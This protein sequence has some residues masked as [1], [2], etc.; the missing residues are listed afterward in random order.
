MPP[1]DDADRPRTRAAVREHWTGRTEDR[2]RT[3]CVILTGTPDDA[4]SARVAGLADAFEAAGLRPAVIPADGAGEAARDASLVLLA[5]VTHRT[6]ALDALIAR[7]NDSGRPTVVDVGAEALER[8]RDD[9]RLTPDAEALAV[10]C[11]A[12]VAPNGARLTAARAAAPRTMALPTLLTR[13]RVSALREARERATPGTPLVVGW[14]IGATMPAAYRDAVAEGVAT[15]LE[16][17]GA[18][19][20]VVGAPDA[21]PASLRSHSRVSVVAPDTFGP[22][23]LASWSLHVWTPALLG[24]ALLDDTRLLEEASCAGVA[25]VFPASGLTGVDGVVSPHVLVKDFARPHGWLD[26][27]HH[28]LDD[29]RVR[30]RRSSEAVRRADSLDGLAVARALVTRLCGWATYRTATEASVA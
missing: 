2:G 16:D 24:D 9:A 21:L 10:A 7:R 26:G 4:T 12:A 11:G 23:A 22:A 1:V 29:D 19:V 8:D 28:V 5:G 30:I 20:E 3:G 27:L 17:H 15:Y 14:R 18:R 25:S 6:A 13:E